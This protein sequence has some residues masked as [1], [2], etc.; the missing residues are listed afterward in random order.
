MISGGVRMPSE[1]SRT[2]TNREFIRLALAVIAVSVVSFGFFAFLVLATGQ[3][4]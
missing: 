2:R 1:E 4:A 3:I